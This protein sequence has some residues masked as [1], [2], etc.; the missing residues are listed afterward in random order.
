[1]AAVEQTVRYK[2]ELVA[3]DL[4]TIRS[5]VLE[6]GISAFAVDR[7]RLQLKFSGNASSRRRNRCVS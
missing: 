1:M 5:S 4:V 6:R 2:R 3:G 7:L